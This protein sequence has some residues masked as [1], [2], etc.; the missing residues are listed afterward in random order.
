[1]R[2]RAR[3]RCLT[4]IDAIGSVVGG[5]SAAF[6]W[7]WAAFDSAIRRCEQA[8][9]VFDFLEFFRVVEDRCSPALEVLDVPLA[10]VV[11][12]VVGFAQARLE[13]V[14]K[15]RVFHD[16]HELAHLAVD[17]VAAAVVGDVDERPSPV[18]AAPAPGIFVADPDVQLTGSERE[19]D[20]FASYR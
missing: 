6:T 13:A 18:Q 4:R 12:C 15:V 14:I 5:W 10:R 17:G 2:F 11:E 1:M 19:N 8:A 3:L 16:V 20:V 9:E 7:R